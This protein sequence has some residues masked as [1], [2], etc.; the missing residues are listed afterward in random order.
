M[1]AHAGALMALGTAIAIAICLHAPLPIRLPD[2]AAF[3]AR[4]D[5]SANNEAAM[6]YTPAGQ[7]MIPLGGDN[8]Q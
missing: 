3:V 8:T 2:L 7:G 1:D 6:Y 5:I 4:Y